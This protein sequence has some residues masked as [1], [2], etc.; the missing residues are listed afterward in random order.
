M[1]D[2]KLGNSNDTISEAVKASRKRVR[3]PHAYL[4]VLGLYSK[5]NLLEDVLKMYK[6][7]VYSY[8]PN[9]PSKAINHY[10]KPVG[11][12]NVNYY[13]TVVNNESKNSKVID[14]KMNSRRVVPN[15]INLKSPQPRY[16][17]LE[18]SLSAIEETR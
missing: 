12:L 11:A 10:I 15:R 3:S 16:N 17:K 6:T 2:N 4:K 13:S 7:A 9:H 5:S 18:T 8:Q 14:M 1:S